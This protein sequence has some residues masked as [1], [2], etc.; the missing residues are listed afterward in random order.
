MN[1]MTH[2]LF[3]HGGLVGSGLIGHICRA[4]RGDGMLTS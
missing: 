1:T 2:I 3:D 4:S